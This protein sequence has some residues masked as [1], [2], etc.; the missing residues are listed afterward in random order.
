MERFPTRSPY[1]RTLFKEIRF[2]A[3]GKRVLL[4]HGS[5]R[6]LNEYLFAQMAERPFVIRRA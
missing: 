2:E 5:P 3:D 4:V 1:P 6:K